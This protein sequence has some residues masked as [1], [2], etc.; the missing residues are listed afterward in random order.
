[1][2]FTFESVNLRHG[3]EALNTKGY[4]SIMDAWQLRPYRLF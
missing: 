2:L 4:L 3:N 1:M